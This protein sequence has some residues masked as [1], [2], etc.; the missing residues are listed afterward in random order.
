M[1]LTLT[2]C[3]VAVIA[4]LNC[5]R[6]GKIVFEDIIT[7][8]TSAGDVHRYGFPFTYYFP[9]EFRDEPVIERHPADG[10]TVNLKTTLITK[11]KWNA[12]IGDVILA[13]LAGIGVSLILVNVFPRSIK[14]RAAWQI[15]M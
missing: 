5:P 4:F 12:V 2:L 9:G 8:D 10:S 11:I 13:C 6:T 15:A 1:F 14:N 7:G 3:A